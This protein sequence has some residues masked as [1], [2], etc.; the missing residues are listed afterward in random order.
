MSPDATGGVGRDEKGASRL[1]VRDLPPP[2]GPLLRLGRRTGLVHADGNSIRLGLTLGAGLWIV[3]AVLAT[4]E[5][6]RNQ[7]FSLSVIGAHVRLLVSIP[8]FFFCETRVERR[9]RTFVRVFARSRIVPDGERE[10]LDTAIARLARR[11][12]S[13]LPEALCLLAAILASALSQRLHLLGITAA[14]DGDRS[15][16]AVWAIQWFSLVCL[17]VF[18]FLLLRWL[19]RFASWALF[20]WRLSRMQ[21]HLIPAHS[22]GVAGLGQLEGVHAEFWSL[23]IG[24][25]AVQAASMAEEVV[26]GR[27]TFEDIYPHVAFTVGAVIVLFIGPLLVFAGKLR[28][29]RAR[30]MCEYMAFAARYADDFERKWITRPADATS[31]PLGTPD[32][33]SLADLTNSVSVVRS[34]RLAPVSRRL[35]LNVVGSA[36]LPLLPLLLFE[37]PLVELAAKAVARLTGL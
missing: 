36:V 17:P 14:L 31:D 18:R 5:G 22:D 23:I 19:W 9:M 2:G 1:A 27:L 8:L 24:L 33:Q 28:E 29:S 7:L 37:Y 25:S 20:L 16:H 32:L 21:L 11:R 12:D 15:A 6:I 34:M 4:A 26:T 35:L 30:G 13:W 10:A 3:L